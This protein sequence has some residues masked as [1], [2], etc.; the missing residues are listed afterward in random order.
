MVRRRRGE[1]P[2]HRRLGRRRHTRKETQPITEENHTLEENKE[3]DH[4]W[5]HK[6]TEN[7]ARESDESFKVFK[8]TLQHPSMTY[9]Q[10]SEETGIPINTVY[11]WAKKYRYSER[12]LAKA[13]YETK[14]LN[15]LE[16]ESKVIIVKKNILRNLV[17]E[18]LLDAYAEFNRKLINWLDVEVVDTAVLKKQ[19]TV[20]KHLNEYLDLRNKHLRNTLDT[21][22]LIKTLVKSGGDVEDEELKGLAGAL[23]RSYKQIEEGLKK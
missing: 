22:E 20:N 19:Q 17:D 6:Y 14:V 23:L 4:I 8:M 7:G 21:E 16:M 10:I 11:D 13:Q 2:W 3:E 9:K 12:R 18:E 5:E 1:K 15:N